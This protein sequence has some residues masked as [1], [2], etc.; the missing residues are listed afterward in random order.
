M[1]IRSNWKSVQS[2]GKEWNNGHKHISS[3]TQGEKHNIPEKNKKQTNKKHQSISDN[4][5]FSYY[6]LVLPLLCSFPLLMNF[7][8]LSLFNAYHN[9]KVILRRE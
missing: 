6:S 7:N 9:K 1:L 4:F 2:F 5:L 3:K 8:Y